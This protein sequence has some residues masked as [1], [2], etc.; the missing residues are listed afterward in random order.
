MNRAGVTQ[1]RPFALSL[2]LNFEEQFRRGTSQNTPP[3]S[4]FVTSDCYGVFKK[5]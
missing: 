3:S 2:A 5:D 4:V 1:V